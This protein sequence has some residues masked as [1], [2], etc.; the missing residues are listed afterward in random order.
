MDM[1]WLLATAEE[2]GLGLNLNILETNLINL[3]IVITV[4][5]YFGRKFLGKTLSGRQAAIEQAISDAEERRSKAAAEL[6]EQQQ[7]LAQAQK[8]A[9]D[10]LAQA[11]ETAAKAKATILAQADADV[12]R[13]KATAAQD[14]SSQEVKVMR[15]LQQRIA[16]LAIAKAE[17][18]LPGRLDAGIQQQLV[19]SSIALLEGGN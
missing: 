14:L 4:L 12:E 8:K 2:G 18:E 7:N 17:A 6:A 3:V 16:E 5:I 19:D 9:K 10:I 15:E 11:E 1:S 13:M